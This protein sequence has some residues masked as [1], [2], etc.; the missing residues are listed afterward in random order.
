[1]QLTIKLP[2]LFETID[3]LANLSV[4]RGHHP[5][6]HFHTPARHPLALGIQ[7]VPVGDLGSDH[8]VRLD[9]GRNEA[10]V[11]E[12][13]ETFETQSVGTG[14]VPSFVGVAVLGGTLKR[15]MRRGEGQVSEEWLFGLLLVPIVEVLEQIVDV[16]SRAVEAFI[17]VV[18]IGSAAEPSGIRAVIAQGRVNDR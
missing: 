5:G 15:P 3:D 4:H 8:I 10:L 2:R 9:I 7:A 16:K 12:P 11:F 14:V 18:R 6:V 1:M 17:V 13:L